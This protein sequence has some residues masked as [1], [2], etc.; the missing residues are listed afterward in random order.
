M[1]PARA[2]ILQLLEY[3]AWA[4]A[5]TMESCAPLSREELTRD[6]QTSHSSVWG[7]LEHIYKA[8]TVWLKRLGGDGNAKLA[9]AEPV[10][11]LS[12]LQKS[13]QRVLAGLISLAGSLNDADW[14]RMAEYRLGNG[15]QWRSPLYETFLHLVNHGTYHRGQ[16]AT[17]LRQL[18]AEPIPTDFIRFVLATVTY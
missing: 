14:K 8:D 2:T 7:T 15:D 4:T 11:D 5:K 17:M 18:G 3:H 9:D 6:M 10:S 16:M 12:G 13:W 1:E